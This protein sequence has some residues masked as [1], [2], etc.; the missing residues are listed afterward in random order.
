[1]EVLKK[2][3]TATAICIVVCIISLLL[4]VHLSVNRQ[5]NKLEDAFYNGV[6]ADG[7][8][9]PSVQQQL[10]DRYDAAIGIISL[11]PS[12]LAGDLRDA[13]DFLIEAETFS[14]KYDA[15]EMLQ[16]AYEDMLQSV[17][18]SMFDERTLGGF[19]DYCSTMDNAQRL[20]ENS[21]YNEAAAEFEDDIL[22]SFPLSI[23]KYPAFAGKPEYFG[24]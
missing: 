8:A 3:S 10:D 16:A 9:H 2:R 24:D 14:E 6:H 15:N 4:G 22:G 23:L 18:A 7:Y 13:C 5:L 20:I 17:D 21:G 11:I 1:M 12:E 19:N